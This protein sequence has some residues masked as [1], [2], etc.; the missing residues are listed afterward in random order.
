[1]R[2][3]CCL[4]RRGLLAFRS[5]MFMSHGSRVSGPTTIQPSSPGDTQVKQ[6]RRQEDMKDREGPSGRK[7]DGWGCSLDLNL[8]C[9][10]CS[11]VLGHSGY[12]SCLLMYILPAYI[13]FV[14]PFCSNFVWVYHLCTYTPHPPRPLRV[15]RCGHAFHRSCVVDG[16]CVVCQ[17]G[18]LWRITSLMEVSM[19][20]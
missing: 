7:E 15:F 5:Q 11:R 6:Q 14:P 17:A 18:A 10:C 19:T 13:S 20:V 12:V 4:G 1:M 8:P 9:P 2:Q 16:A 3:R